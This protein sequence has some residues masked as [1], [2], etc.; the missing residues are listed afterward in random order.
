MAEEPGEPSDGM[1]QP[2]REKPQWWKK[3][4][5]KCKA[6]GRWCKEWA[7]RRSLFGAIA[8]WAFIAI[9]AFL[10]AMC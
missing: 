6:A 5:Q 8:I 1:T 4:S 2:S 9:G 7:G 3:L 10:L